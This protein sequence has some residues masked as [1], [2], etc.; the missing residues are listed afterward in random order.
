MI[1]VTVELVS[2]IHPSRNRLLGVAYISNDGEK[3]HASNGTRGDY[4][5]EITKAGVTGAIWKRTRVLG[6]P[7][8]RLGAWDLLFRALRD[9]VGQRNE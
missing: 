2:A 7:R 1:R 8:R 9:I 4:N 3:F 5:V 6:F